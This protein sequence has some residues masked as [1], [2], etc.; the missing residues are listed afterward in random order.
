MDNLIKHL[1]DPSDKF[2][3]AI[4]F[5]DGYKDNLINALPILE[6]YSIPATIYITTRFPERD[7]WMWWYE[8]WD[9][10]QKVDDLEIFF[11]SKSWKWKTDSHQK[12]IYCY[13]QLENWMINL[14]SND[15][16]ILAESV[17][18]SPSRKQYPELCLTWDEINTLDSHRLV[19]VGAHTHT[20]PNLRTLDDEEAFF[21][22]NHSK[23]L[24]KRHL[25]HDIEHF[26][27]PYGTIN[28]ADKREFNLV[29]RCNF[30][31][32]VTTRADSITSTNLNA[33][34]RLGIEHFLS[35]SDLCAKL[36][37]WEHLVR[38]IIGKL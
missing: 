1:E 23:N 21:E 34:P 19:T 29:D 13:R 27:Y 14:H 38:N 3:V 28:E 31:S 37:G 8:L 24:L 2:V 32:A 17:T 26:A 35:A 25:E 18:K 11:Q 30:R 6:R 33:I 20:H 7:T 12:K 5:D 16:K 9:H 10:L 36:S 15:Q 4:T 22:I